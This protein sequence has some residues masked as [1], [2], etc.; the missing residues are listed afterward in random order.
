MDQVIAEFDAAISRYMETTYTT[1][2]QYAD[3][4]VVKSCTIADV[5][6]KETLNDV[7]SEVADTSIR[8][9]LR[10]F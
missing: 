7:L 6:D 2:Q 4:L 1:P 3:N 5:Y 8:H 10:Q 9:S